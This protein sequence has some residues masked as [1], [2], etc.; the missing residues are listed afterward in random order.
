[1]EGPCLTDLRKIALVFALLSELLELKFR[2][3]N[4]V[5]N[6]AVDLLVA[7][8]MAVRTG[9]GL[10]QSSGTGSGLG[11]SS[12]GGSDSAVICGEWIGDVGLMG[13]CTHLGWRNGKGDSVGYQHLHMGAGLHPRVR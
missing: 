9:S 3:Q 12:G 4:M 8:G 2:D 13:T 1:M 7:V 5:L 11:Q 6:N 10:G